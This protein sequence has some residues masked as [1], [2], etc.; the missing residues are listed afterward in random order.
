MLHSILVALK[1][2]PK[3]AVT[4]IVAALPLA[5]LRGSIPLALAMKMSPLSA[6]VW[7]I[8]GNS[9]V[10]PPTLL[11]LEPVSTRLRRFK[12]WKRFF[13]WLFERTREKG[14]IVQKY[15][16]L[17]LM[18]FVAIP[19][20]LTG[21]WSGCVAA[22]LF[23]IKFRYAF[24]AIFLGVVIAGIVVMATCLFGIEAFKIFVKYT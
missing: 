19:L 22:S 15:E 20:P 21:A 11:L 23:K 5:E 9:L 12:L 1:G 7:S 2:L 17:G 14:D 10:I 16:S 24:T 18:I 8:I 3:E 4:L 6:F 13:D